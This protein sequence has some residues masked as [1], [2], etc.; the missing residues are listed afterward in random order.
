MHSKL[1]SLIV[2]GFFG[3]HRS[4]TLYLFVYC[5][6]TRLKL[7]IFWIIWNKRMKR[8]EKSGSDNWACS[9]RKGSGYTMQERPHG[10]PLP[11]RPPQNE[12]HDNTSQ[13][14]VLAFYLCL[15]DT[16]PPPT[17][18]TKSYNAFIQ[19]LHMQINFFIWTFRRTKP[20]ISILF[21]PFNGERLIFKTSQWIPNERDLTVAFL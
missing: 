15:F 8:L 13:W 19:Y 12:S 1:Y 10:R 21:N 9:T 14:P 11:L 2:F 6:N 17:K 16:P 4:Q 5:S 3:K 7:Q 18:K 20:F